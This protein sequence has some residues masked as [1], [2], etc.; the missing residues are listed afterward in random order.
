MVHSGLPQVIRRK[1]FFWLSSR[2]DRVGEL[3]GVGGAT[4]TSAAGFWRAA[5]HR[6]DAKESVIRHTPA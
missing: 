2:M 4:R 3:S 5:R 6:V 1:G